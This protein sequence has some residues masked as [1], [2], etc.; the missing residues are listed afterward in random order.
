[1]KNLLFTCFFF[2]SIVS[3]AQEFVPGNVY[4]DDNEFVEYVAGNLPIVLSA[5]HGGYLEPNNIPDRSCSGCVYVADAY[6]EDLA[7]EVQVA[8][9]EA[10]GCY[11]HVVINLLHRKKFDA[12]RAIGEAADGNAT[13]Q[14]SWWA[15][16]AFLDS[17]KAQVVRDYGRGLFL[18]LHGHGHDIQ[19]IELGYTLS[20]SEL[21]ESD[22]T[23]NTSDYI[24]DN[25]IRTL[26]GDN[27]LD[28]SAAELVRGSMSF[29]ALL[30]ESGY[31]SVPSE[32]T[33]YPED[34]EPY[35]SGGFNTQRHGSEDGGPIDGIQI[36]CNQNI[37]FEE[38]T[39]LEFAD[40]LTQAIIDYMDLHYYDG[41]ASEY[42]NLTVDT[43]DIPSN[44]SIAIY[45]NPAKD[46][47]SISSPWDVL[48]VSIYNSLGQVEQNLR[49]MGG[50]LM[51]SDL[52]KGA[53]YLEFRHQ[54]QTVG[55][56]VLLKQ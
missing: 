48:D 18:D 19:R 34:D 35:F 13:V 15:Y 22:A 8:F 24:M 16:H 38:D 17:A 2:F 31:S 20:K 11:P 14:E 12:N 25:S 50:D 46:Y 45:P 30:D 44:S 10:T 26:V 42:C 40:G 23:L 47:L 28:L 52:P 41:F 3:L 27:L 1:M 33:P 56:Q 6:T 4:F 37:R 51:I 7:R 55:R 49:W 39:R 54:G 21:Q 36:E 5:P 43:E 9:F 53:H 29:G 32:D